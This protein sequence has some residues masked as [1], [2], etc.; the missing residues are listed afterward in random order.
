MELG[1][2]V[3]G[4]HGNLYVTAVDILDSAMRLELCLYRTVTCTLGIVR[5][6]NL[7]WRL[8]GRVSDALILLYNSAKGSIFSFA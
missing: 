7:L 4:K 6:T 3:Q 8:Y 5:S 2:R 1:T